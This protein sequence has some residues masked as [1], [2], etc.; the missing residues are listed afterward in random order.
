MKAI[1]IERRS[2]FKHVSGGV[3]GTFSVFGDLLSHFP[4]FCSLPSLPRSPYGL[5]GAGCLTL[6]SSSLGAFLVRVTF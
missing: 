5:S 4:P 6:F 1:P 3:K 2:S